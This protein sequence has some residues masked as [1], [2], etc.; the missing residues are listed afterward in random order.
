V[1]ALE[2]EIRPIDD[3]RST[4]AYRRVVAGNLLRL[5]WVQTDR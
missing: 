3:L 2:T 4:E 1:R 5:F